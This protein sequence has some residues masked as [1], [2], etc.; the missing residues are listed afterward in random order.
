MQAGSEDGPE[1]KRLARIARELGQDGLALDLEGYTPVDLAAWVR[2]HI[3]TVMAA[4]SAAG[5]DRLQAL[6]T[7][8]K[9]WLD[10]LKKRVQQS[11]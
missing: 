2:E 6:S 8:D 11:K 4:I 10:A 7:A 9:L 1:W 3:G 5:K